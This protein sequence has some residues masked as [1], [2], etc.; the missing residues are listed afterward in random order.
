MDLIV[1]ASIAAKWFF[2]EE[3]TAHA[4]TFLEKHKLGKIEIKFPLI[5][6]FELGNITLN[7]KVEKQTDFDQ[8]FAKLLNN[9]GLSVI[10]PEEKIYQTTF[11]IA[12][13]YKLSFYDAI[14]IACA[15]NLNCE[16]ITADKKLYQKTKDLKFVKLLAKV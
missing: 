6:L 4:M 3:H 9:L 2:K 11:A 7:K 14:Y 8:I 13:K 12:I 16:F 15:Q 1:D 10:Y 5:L